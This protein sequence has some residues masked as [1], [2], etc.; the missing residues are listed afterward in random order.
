MILEL[1]E[2]SGPLGID[3]ALAK[4]YLHETSDDETRRI[5]TAYGF[6]KRGMT[7][8]KLALRFASATVTQR[9][10]QKSWLVQSYSYD[11]GQRVL[12]GATSDS[13]RV[14]HSTGPEGLGAAAQA[15]FARLCDTQ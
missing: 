6:G 2:R 15:L 14:R 5:R 7:T 10:R 11:P 8:S 4:H 12:S 1:L 13:V 9:H 3:F